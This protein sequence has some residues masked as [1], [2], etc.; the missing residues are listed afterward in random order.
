MLGGVSVI[1]SA[2][3]IT[4]KGYLVTIG[5]HNVGSGIDKACTS[6]YIVQYEQIRS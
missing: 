2:F 5:R 4:I 6:K 1:I 3:I